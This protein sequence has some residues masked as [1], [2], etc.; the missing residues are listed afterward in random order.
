MGKIPK[1]TAET[2]LQFFG[3][4]A[5]SISHELKN[6]LAIINENAGLL[7]D[8]AF[9]AEKGKPIDPE[10]LK[11]M[12]AAVQKQIGRADHILK[13]MN[14]FAHSTDE[15]VAAVDLGQ[16]LELVISLTERFAARQ[17]VNVALKLPPDSPTITTVPFYL[18]NLICLCLDFSMSAAGDGKRLE[19]T[20]ANTADAVFIH[21]SRLTGLTPEMLEAFPSE[22]EK[23]LLAILAADLTGQPDSK[24]ITLRLPNTL[25]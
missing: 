1:D 24:K 2:G 12:A 8:F 21:F 7:E 23:N 10:R 25:E 11:L 16:L 19:L 3:R 6:V 13:N 14:R 9:L 15:R 20:I 4:L 17:R 18:I 22:S 5:A